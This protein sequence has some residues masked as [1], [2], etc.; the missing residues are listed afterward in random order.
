MCS[1]K[2]CNAPT[3]A[4]G[5]CARHY[6][7]L[8]THGSADVVQQRGRKPDPDKIAARKTFKEWSPR[9]FERYWSAITL[10]KASGISE[11]EQ[12]QA[13]RNATRKW[14]SINVARL[15]DVAEVIYAKK[16]KTERCGI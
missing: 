2:G 8:R 15:I 4:K 14:G 7:R 13:I 10:L 5:M 11:E 6:M 1:I 9:T 12:R 3:V 16:Q